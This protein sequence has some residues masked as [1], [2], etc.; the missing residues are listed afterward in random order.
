[1]LNVLRS[2]QLWSWLPSPGARR[3]A[4]VR[5]VGRG[6]YRAASVDEVAIEAGVSLASFERQFQGKDDC[7]LA[8]YD[9]LVERLLAEVST[10][11]DA[12]LEWRNRIERGLCTIVERF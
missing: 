1:M 7:F 12:E 3:E 8:A 10:S 2:L 9:M 4:I 6:G 11:C 5:V